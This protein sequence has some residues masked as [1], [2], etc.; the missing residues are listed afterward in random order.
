[1]DVCVLFGGAPGCIMYCNGS[2]DTFTCYRINE[3]V[4][5]N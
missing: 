5:H 3:D 2:L 1:M 4:T